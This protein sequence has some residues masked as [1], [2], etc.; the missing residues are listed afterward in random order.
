MWSI[1]GS[2]PGILRQAWGDLV[3]A[4][5]KGD[6]AAGRPRQAAPSGDGIPN[7]KVIGIGKVWSRILCFLAEPRDA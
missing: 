7:A 4:A 2:L 3:A 5:L 1:L 6:Q